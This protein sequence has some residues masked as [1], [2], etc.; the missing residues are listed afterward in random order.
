MLVAEQEGLSRSPSQMGL[1][2]PFPKSSSDA[3]YIIVA[4]DYLTKWAEIASLNTGTADE[5][6]RFSANK[7]VLR[8]G[9]PNSIVSDHGKCFVAE[10][11][12]EVLKLQETNHLTPTSYHPQTNGLCERLNHTLA[13]MLSMYISS[14]HRN[15]DAIL[16]FVTFTYN[17]FK[18]ESTRYTPFFLLYGRE[19]MLPVDAA[20]GVQINPLE[21]QNEAD[22]GYGTRV[23]ERLTKAREVVLQNLRKVRL[24]QKSY[25]D[26]KRRDASFTAG[27]L[28]LIYKPF[29]KVGKSEKL[30]HRWLGPYQVIRRISYL[31][32]EVKLV[33][34]N[35]GKTD[36]VHVVAMKLFHPP[37]KESEV[38]QTQEPGEGIKPSIVK[39]RP[40]RPKEEIKIS[41]PSAMTKRGPGRHRKNIVESK[42]SET[43]GLRQRPTRN[44][45]VPQRLG[46]LQALFLLMMLG[47][48]LAEPP[49]T[50][51]VYFDKQPSI[52]ISDSEWIITTELT[53]TNASKSI[54]TLQEY[55]LD[56]VW[57]P[58]N[59]GSNQPPSRTQIL[60]LNYARKKTRDALLVLETISNRLDLIQNS[61]HIN[62]Q[63]TPEEPEPVLSRGLI[64]L[65]GDILKWVFGTPNN[66]DLEELNKR[67]QENHKTN[68]EI[69]HSLEDQATIISENL[70]HTSINT[71]ALSELREVLSSLDREFE[72]FKQEQG[73][74]FEYFDFIIKIDFA[75]SGIHGQID[76]LEQYVDNLSIG[77]AT[78]SNGHLP[79]ELFSPETFQSVLQT[80]TNRLPAN[81][82]MAIKDHPD[83]LWKFYQETKVSVAVSAHVNPT[84]LYGVKLFLHIPIYELKFQFQLY[85][86]F[87][88]PVYNFNATHGIQYE[89]M[90]DYLAVSAD[91]ESYM[92]LNE[93]DIVQCQ[94]TTPF[95]ICPIVQALR[96]MKTTPSCAVS[97]FRN[98]QDK[99]EHC[100]QILVPWK[101]TYSIYLG[102]QKWLYSDKQET[103]V[104]FACANTGM[105]IRDITTRKIDKVSIL[106][107]PRGCTV[108]AKDWILPPVFKKETL[109]VTTTNPIQD[110]NVVWSD[111]NFAFNFATVVPGEDNLRQ[112]LLNN[113]TEQIK[114]LQEMSTEVHQFDGMSTKR[115]KHLSD[116]VVKELSWDQQ[117]TPTI[118][119]IY[120][121]LALLTIFLA[122]DIVLG[123]MKC[124]CFE[125][126]IKQLKDRLFQHEKMEIEEEVVIEATAL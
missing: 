18:Q 112:Q 29:R 11:T 34:N 75:F 27:D 103:V 62:K 125:R 68:V 50:E 58:H 41:A 39:R 22:K 73:L 32:Y 86:V 37:T 28:V 46:I 111:F 52:I 110:T 23:M 67:L 89:K 55:L 115:L 8:H 105:T 24:A 80:I 4:V 82:A 26:Q 109:T 69:V 25:Y 123:F 35:S 10:L 97:L 121:V 99:H 5:V 118:L 1:L 93:R 85:K 63:N 78:L 124:R 14:D 79:P 31:N 100:A 94:K 9:A 2:G 33:K 116:Q 16:P 19:A 91:Q 49:I 57:S 114:T 70:H 12:Q 71:E 117:T 17:R 119:G 44:R 56:R 74:D 96:R 76:S 3:R 87:N 7:I 47:L 53:F 51:G 66:N 107:V 15:W 30:L 104:N 88:L 6:A 122:I 126:E 43:T 120:S 21:I 45:T 108:Y 64:N 38:P 98:D 36:I 101:G 81:W 20:L 48:T 83:N 90:A 65:G 60:L 59:E 54:R 106:E 42:V 84:Y 13:G 102:N 77:F 72:K 113:I 95:W 92:L 61:V 40:G